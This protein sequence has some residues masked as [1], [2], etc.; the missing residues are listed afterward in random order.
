MKRIAFSLIA[1]IAL[2]GVVALMAQ[3]VLIIPC[4]TAT[5]IDS[6]F[7]FLD[8]K[9]IQRQTQNNGRF[10]LRMSHHSVGG[11]LVSPYGPIQSASCI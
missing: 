11:R 5:V 10:N 4:P 2:T 6:P 8:S 1:V 7:L 3:S 9:P